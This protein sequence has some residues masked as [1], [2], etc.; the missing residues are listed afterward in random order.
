MS[1]SFDVTHG[2]AAQ[3]A[4]VP[5]VV[6]WWAHGIHAGE[7]ATSIEADAGA[8]SAGRVTVIAS[9][10]VH[11]LSRVECGRGRRGHSRNA[12]ATRCLRRC[13]RGRHRLTRA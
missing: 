6:D 2:Y 3:T 12:G 11:D 5:Y 4:R 1:A 8:A 13:R 10:R 9:T 7:R